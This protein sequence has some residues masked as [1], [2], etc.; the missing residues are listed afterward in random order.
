M[1]DIDLEVKEPTEAVWLQ[2]H[3][4]TVK[5]AITQI[6]EVKQLYRNDQRYRQLLDY[7]TALEGL[8]RH[9]GVHAAR[10]VM[11]SGR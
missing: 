9:A 10:R 5:E 2:G 1:L 7:A 3:S 8:S 11:I 4:L 6:A